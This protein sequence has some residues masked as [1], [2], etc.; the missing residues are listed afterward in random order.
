[1][2]A[3]GCLSALKVSRIN[4]AGFYTDGGGLY[5][6]VGSGGAKSWIYRFT[7]NGRTRDMGLGGLLEVTLA[8]ARQR[9]AECRRLRSQGIDP[10]EA[11]HE[12]R[13]EKLISAARTICFKECA[14]TYIN[15]HRP[16]WKNA[17]YAI[18]WPTSME[19]YVYPVFGDLAV[20]QVDTALV[21]KVLEP[22]WRTKNETAGRIRG[23]I[24][25]ILDWAT[26][27]GYRSG[28]NPARWRGHL[29]NLLAEPSKFRRVKHHS[30]LPYQEVGSFLLDLR[31]EDCTSARAFEFLILTA[32]RTSETIKARWAEIDLEQQIWTIPAERMKSAREHRVPLSGWAMSILEEMKAERCGDLIFPSLREGRP[33]S[34]MALLA[35]LRRMNRQD[36]T[37]HGFRSTYR[38][39]AAEQ[40]KFSREVAEMALAHVTENKVEAAYQRSDLFKKRRKL[41]NAWAKY[42]ARPAAKPKCLLAGPAMLVAADGGIAEQLMAV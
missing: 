33:L 26:S 41:M 10:V 9:A 18:Q 1:M 24:E 17:K 19:T 5:L 4:S 15:T 29:N 37:A 28:E 21:L 20:Q 35:L 39:W 11:R 22:I 12:A 7:L 14:E 27:R 36:I 6:Q 40:T 3:L 2:R 13:R 30:S 38:V 25:A 32:T 42:C 31:A 34:D 8:E 16:T 23:R